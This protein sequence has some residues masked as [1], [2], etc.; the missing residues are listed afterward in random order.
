MGFER[1]EKV[2]GSHGVKDGLEATEASAKVPA[3]QLRQMNY[4]EGAALLAPKAPVVQR[5]KSPGG[6]EGEVH[7][8]AQAGTQGGGAA[9]PHLAQI[10]AAFGAHDLSSVQSYSGGAATQANQ[11]MGAE[12][13]ATGNKIAFGSSPSLHTVA[14]EAAHVIQQRGG[15]SLSGGVGQ[16][17]DSY[18][19]NADAV[20]DAVVAGKSAEG[21]LGAHSG[22]RSVQRKEG[23]VQHFR[24]GGNKET[25][26]GVSGWR[27][28]E[29]EDSAVSQE[30]GDGGYQL[31]ASDTKIASG[32]A[33]LLGATSG[34]MLT[35]GS[36]TV[37]VGGKT[38]SEA[39][40][41][42]N[43]KVTT[44][45]DEKLQDVNAGT[46]KADDGSKQ[47]DKL[48]LWTDCGRASRV[49]TGGFV[50]AKYQ[51]EGGEAQ[52]ALAGNPA[53]FSDEI[54]DVSMR[55]FLANPANES[56]L[57]QGIHYRD[58]A[59]IAGSLIRP[60]NAEQ[61]R[62]QFGH[63][64]PGGADAFSQAFG[65]NEY[66]NP[67]VGETYTMAT[68]YDMP[69]FESKGMTW[70][71]HWAGVI[72]KD[73]ADNI[74]CEGYAIDPS[75]RIREARETYKKPGDRAK[76]KAEVAKI[77]SWASNYVDR[78][79]RIQMYGTALKEQSFQHEHDASQTHGTRNST[80]R[81]GK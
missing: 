60:R 46:L 32:N 58:A 57:A 48:G 18:E 76:L 47:D 61:A 29:H 16:A 63:L 8:A 12:A 62:N 39:R 25:D 77:R 65:I 72:M 68:E 69:G 22:A 26:Q 31:F 11:A 10:Q 21:L 73:G 4:D 35:K 23:A 81:A 74:T 19:K 67:E 37:Q 14:H 50:G 36:Q 38:L 70:N 24:R 44:P 34:I 2:K 51:R 30:T 27:I 41:A 79:F 15:V 6:G 43:P 40:P 56:F 64:K 45:D 80:F 71:F 54:Y 52:T 33:A 17:G 66:A 59:D 55:A 20:A 13:Y 7:Q 42:L 9:L 3:L 1:V 5:K 53:A 75:Q 49:V 28:G 78:D